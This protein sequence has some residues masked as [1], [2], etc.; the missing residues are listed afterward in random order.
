[1]SSYDYF[2]PAT[3]FAGGSLIGLAAATLLLFNGDILGA[4]GIL[5]SILTAPL[6]TFQDTSQFWK[7]ILISSFMFTAQYLLG[8]E[9]IEDGRSISDP[10]VPIPSQLA[11][12]LGGLLVGFGSTLGNGC[13]SGHGVCGL[14]RRSR[15][16]FAGVLSFMASAITTVTLTSPDSSLSE[17]TTSLR[18]STAS[19]TDVTLGAQ[20]TTA[21]ISLS[22]LNYRL[23]RKR[24]SSEDTSKLYASSV[25]G[26][27][28]A[29]GLAIGQMVLGSKLFG[30][31]NV[32]SISSGTWD[33]T[34]MTVLG[35][36]VPISMIA[37]EFVKGFS[38]L[39]RNMLLS[40]PLG[41]VQKFGIPTNTVIDKHLIVGAALF[42]AGWGLSLLCPG[43]ALFHIA[44]GNTNVI[45]RWLPA[46]IAGACLAKEVKKRNI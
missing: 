14:G 46:Y 38:L 10:S 43:P 17:Y 30:F 44:A 39:N 22:V 25:S 20:I 45:F 1:M 26:A 33:P 37:Y 29:A 9:Y 34:L 41:D 36:A 24:F 21:I 5:T 16:S 32:T 19:E 7:L 15:R 31:L 13:T 6:K 11:Y 35:A 12:V 42:G 18:G 8:V 23:N 2:T 4:S 27:L 3:G 40:K 28:F